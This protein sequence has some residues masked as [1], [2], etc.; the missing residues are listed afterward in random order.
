MSR[1]WLEQE[2][3]SW[4]EKGII[5]S[6]QYKRILDLYPE[7]KRAIGLIPLLGSILVGL[8][9][10]SFVA[11][12][13]QVIPQLLR[14]SIIIL[15]MIAFYITGDRLLKKDHHN[16]GIALISLGLITFGA[17]I[18]LI[19]QM[20]H[21]TAYDATS[22]IV[23]GSAGLLLTY[24]YT[25]RYLFLLTLLVFTGSQLYST[26]EFNHFSYVS[27]VIMGVGL[28]FYWWNN[29]NETI[30]WGLAL[31]VTL[32]FLLLVTSNAW[33]FTWFF[34][35]VWLLYAGVDWLKDRRTV[36]PFQA[37]TLIAAFVFNLFI[38]LFWSNDD[39]S[40]FHHGLAANSLIYCSLLI[41]LLGL[42]LTGKA[43][44]NRLS[45]SL[46]WVLAIPFFYLNNGIDV[47]YLLTLFTF[48][49]YLLWRG[50]AE[51]WR[52]KINL[53]TLLFLCS[54]MTAYGKLAWGFMDKSIF[55]ILGGL[56]LLALSWF[57]NRRKK[58]FLADV[59]E[60]NDHEHK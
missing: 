40:S 15:A 10:L 28:G 38:I 27:F 11:A 1:R 52:L 45:S 48:S 39:I 22:I 42:S 35:P 23:W 7:Q 34:I 58:Q 49:L 30:G 53:G 50:Y 9:I 12:N 18:I 16:L 5:T 19:A 41:L 26:T 31:S 4:S 8:G 24:L 54:T 6:D 29:K 56:I 21:L 33:P 13:W 2:G 60:D 46:D 59:E 43:R 25:S 20:F 3:R 57:L 51:E 44:N 55:F 47:L 37:V 17:G 32:Q 14:L 36:Y